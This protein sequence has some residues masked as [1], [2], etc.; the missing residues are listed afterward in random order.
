ME[1][2]LNLLFIFADQWRRSAVGFAKADPVHTPNIDRFAARS[3]VFTNAVSA[4]PLCSPHRASLLTGRQP[5]STGVFTNCKTG[6]S[7]R[8]N[9]DEICISDV[10]HNRGYKTAYIGK[11]HLDEPEGN[12]SS[13]PRSGAERWDAYT[14]PGPRRHGF[15]MWHSYG[16]W[17]DHLHPHYWENSP[18]KI[19]VNQWSPE[20]ETDT[21]IGWIGKQTDP[22]CLFMSWNPPHS[23]YSEVPEKYLKL[24]DPRSLPL[25]SNVLTGNIHQHTGEEMPM[26]ELE[27]R[28]TTCQY[29]AAVSGLDEQFGRIIQT[30]KDK[31]LLDST[32]VVLSSDHGDMMGSHGLMAKH[33]WHEESIGIPLVIGGAG[34]QPGTGGTVT[35]SADMMPTLLSLLGQPIPDTVEG[36]DCSASL[37]G[38]MD[39]EKSCLIATCPGRDI[40]LKEFAGAGMDPR[41]S[42]WRALRTE[43]YT[44]VVDAGYS[45]VARRPLT[46]LLYD[47]KNDPFQMHPSVFTRSSLRGNANSFEQELRDLLIKYNDPFM[48]RFS[49]EP[50]QQD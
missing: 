10:L 28:R 49:Q 48:E 7:M 19:R 25:R 33:V 11:W 6:L 24:Y 27:L 43:G 30:L 13:Q 31:D 46:R 40:F 37:K 14:P 21:A 15:E 50:Q 44:Y 47:L 16:A 39:R 1:K 42:G 3:F 35:G 32:V 9:D 26:D 20:H 38:I 41:S 4:C 18:E 2:K 36:E 45:P 5:L 29:Y 17:D 23:P 34:I 22:F 8:L 12:N